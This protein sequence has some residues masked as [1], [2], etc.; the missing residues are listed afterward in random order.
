MSINSENNSHYKTLDIPENATADEIKKAYRSGSLKYHPDKNP[1]KPEVVEKFQKINEAYEILGNPEKRTEYDMMQKNPFM[2][3]GMGGMNM[4]GMHMGGMHMNGMGMRGMNMNGMSFDN[5]DD[6]FSKLFFG[7]NST[8]MGDEEN[9]MFPP[10]VNIQHI[11]RNGIPMQRMNQDTSTL[12][13][14][15]Q[16]VKNVVI[17]MEQVLNGGKI[18]VEI[19]RWVLDN[20]NKVYEK[21]T[22]YID[23][24]KGIDN[25]EIII[26]KD[27]GNIINEFCKGD[28]KIIINIENETKFERRGLDLL[29]HHKISLK[30]SLCGFSF[31]FKHLNGKVYTI[32]N[33]SGNIIPPDFEK[34]I[35]NMGLTREEYTGSLIIHFH[36]IFP[37][38]LSLKTIETLS[39]ILE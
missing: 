2:R 39:N 11:F 20:W 26:L 28:I 14:P 31:E 15:K 5:I 22:I 23:I 6:L 37:E 19:D 38:T 3:G 10:G 35:P 17:T 8:N 12:Q 24:I 27:Q 29:F 33:N 36:V 13:K 25:N 4:G 18:P 34:I 9:I 21:I 30:N 16:I 1:G 7:G 32:N